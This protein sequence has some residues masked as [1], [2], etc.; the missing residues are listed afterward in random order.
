MGGPAP[1][2]TGVEARRLGDKPE[3]ALGT[4]QG[5]VALQVKGATLWS[6]SRQLLNF[7]FSKTRNPLSYERLLLSK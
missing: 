4:A 5:M 2:G 1:P 3:A 7:N 6:D